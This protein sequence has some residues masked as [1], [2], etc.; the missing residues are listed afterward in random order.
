MVFGEQGLNEV[1]ETNRVRVGNGFWHFM[2][3]VCSELSFVL[4]SEWGLLSSEMKKADSKRPH[5]RFEVI[6]P[7]ADLLRGLVQRCSYRTV[8]KLLARSE[9]SA[10]AQVSYLNIALVI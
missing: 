6:E 9:L 10:G 1:V 5:I 3:D 2:L 7:T 8:L 4:A